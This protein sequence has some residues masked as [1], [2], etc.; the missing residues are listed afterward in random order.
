MSD[1]LKNKIQTD[2]QLILRIEP[3]TARDLGDLLYELLDL[4]PSR[5]R[6][7]FEEIEFLADELRR[8]RI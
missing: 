4:C 7:E 5:Y 1:Y 6:E 3:A 8:A 2:F